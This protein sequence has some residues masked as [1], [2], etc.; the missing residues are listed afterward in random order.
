M[1]DT[2]CSSCKNTYGR[3]GTTFRADVRRDGHYTCK[4]T[5]YVKMSYKGD[6]VVFRGG[7]GGIPL[8]W[9]TVLFIR[10]IEHTAVTSALRPTQPL[11]SNIL[12]LEWFAVLC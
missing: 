1:I 4:G 7:G 9:S 2:Q 10:D 5:V 8:N 6:G 12:T 11:I 3:D